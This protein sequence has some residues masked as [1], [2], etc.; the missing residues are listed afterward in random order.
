MKLNILPSAVH[1]PRFSCGQ[2][3]GQGIGK[4]KKRTVKSTHTNTP[5]PRGPGS[6]NFVPVVRDRNCM[7]NFF[8]FLHFTA[9]RNPRAAGDAVCSGSS[10]TAGSSVLW[11]PPLQPPPKVRVGLEIG[12]YTK[13]DS[14]SHFDYATVA[15]RGK[16]KRCNILTHFVRP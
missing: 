8:F 13:A 15:A 6:Y 14:Y 12:K 2:S 3:Q 16:P 5:H 1:K 7:S 10:S 4:C 11:P 9:A